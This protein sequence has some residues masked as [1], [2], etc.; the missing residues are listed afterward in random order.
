MAGENE[1]VL[2]FGSFEI[3]GYAH[4]Y[5]QEHDRNLT[6]ADSFFWFSV[7]CIVCRY[8]YVFS[9]FIDLDVSFSFLRLKLTDMQF[10]ENNIAVQQ[11]LVSLYSACIND[12]QTMSY[13]THLSTHCVV[14]SVVMFSQ[15]IL[16]AFALIILKSYV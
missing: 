1:L 9:Q 10:W 3:T 4:R 13:M 2:P 15:H 12:I 16:S 14:I 5:G 6:R 8:L 11:L 7:Y